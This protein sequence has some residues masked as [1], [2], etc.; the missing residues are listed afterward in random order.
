MGGA[1]RCAQPVCGAGEDGP[2]DLLALPDGNFTMVGFMA[3]TM[4]FGGPDLVSAGER[5]IFLATL[6]PERAVVR[7]R[8]RGWQCL[9]RRVKW[10]AQT[11]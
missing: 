1:G 2:H 10:R 4:N 6:D 5:D 7:L 8:A 3:D 11:S 9:R